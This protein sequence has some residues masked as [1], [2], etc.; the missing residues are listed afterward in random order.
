MK[1][2]SIGSDFVNDFLSLFGFKINDFYMLKYFA[3]RNRNNFS[4]FYKLDIALLFS[5]TFLIPT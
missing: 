2:K 1:W 5:Y 3:Y 4:N